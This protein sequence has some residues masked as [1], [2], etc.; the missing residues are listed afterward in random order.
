[1]PL[2][3]TEKENS[4]QNDDNFARNVMTS[5]HQC[6]STSGL[7]TEWTK[8]NAQKI[9]FDNFDYARNILNRHELSKQG[10]HSYLDKQATSSASLVTKRK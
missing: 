1:M 10:Y 3:I 8:T 7:S 2:R 4:S 5:E 6:S 9:R